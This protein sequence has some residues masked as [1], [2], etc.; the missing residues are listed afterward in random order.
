MRRNEEARKEGGEKLGVLLVGVGGAVATTFMAGVE[1]IRRGFG[2][3]VGSLSQLG[4]LALSPDG[5]DRRS[6]KELLPLASMEELVFGGWDIF[7]EDCYEAAVGAGVLSK[8]HLGLVRDAL[9][10][11]EIFEGVFERRFVSSLE[12]DHTKEG[13]YESLFEAASLV[14]EEIRAFKRKSGAGRAVMINCAS[15]EAHIELEEER[16][17]R[18]HRSVEDFERALKEN[19]SHP[20]IPP[21][22]LYAYAAIEEGVPYANGTPSLGAH[23]A[24][25]KELAEHRGVAISGKD[26]KSGQT[27]IKSALAP[28]IKARM[29]GMEGWFSTNILGNRDGLVLEAPQNFKSKELTKRSVLDA[30]LEPELYP[31]LY[32]EL[33]HRVEINYYPPRGDA[34]EGW[35]NIDIFGWLG[36]P[37]QIKL[38]FLCRDSILAAPIVLDLALFM[39]LAQRLSYG[40][41]GVQR[42]LSFY[43]KSPMVGEEARERPEHDLFAQLL[44]LR[45][46]LREMAGLSSA[47]P[48]D[49]SSLK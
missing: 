12:G 3:P 15:T 42:W 24:A 16:W 44:M 36:Y 40:G 26:F 43:Y 1:L 23:S 45:G 7:G 29:L 6:I 8:E 19:K 39:D 18:V 25:L 14:R 22:A 27:F 32:G 10:E 28:A 37:M 35:D 48:C 33:Y 38:N 2:R 41:G 34:K 47:S 20:A 17:G 9:R 11:V 49:P 46:A 21:S 31:E 4:R 5:E 13:Q 30:I